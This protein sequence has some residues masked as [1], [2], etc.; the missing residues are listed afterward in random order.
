MQTDKFLEHL[1]NPQKTRQ[2]LLFSD[3]KIED[4]VHIKENQEDLLNSRMT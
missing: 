1:R 3:Q 4:Y 2:N